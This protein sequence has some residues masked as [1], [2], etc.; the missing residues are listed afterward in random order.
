ME[1]ENLKEECVKLFLAGKNYTEIAKLTNYSRSYIA[2]LIKD[3]NR[4]KEKLNTKTVKVYKLKNSTRMKIPISTDFL[5]KIGIDKDNKKE[6]YVE[7]NLD[8][9]NKSIIIKKNNNM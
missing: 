8:E 7:I 1:K 9:K 4:V 6:E 3:D 2:N 5:S